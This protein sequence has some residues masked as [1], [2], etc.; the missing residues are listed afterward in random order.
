MPDFPVPPRSNED[1]ERAAIDLRRL[2][3]LDQAA[4]FIGIRKIVERASNLRG[5]SLNGLR[6]IELSDPDMNQVDASA[7]GFAQFDPPRITIRKSVMERAE[8]GDG[9]ARM[10]VVHE[11][12]HIWLN[13]RGEAKFRTRRFDTSSFKPPA[14]K[15]AEHQASYGAAAFMM[16]LD[17]LRP[18]DTITELCSRYG[19][20][21]RAAEIRIEQR[22]R[23]GARVAPEEVQEF[24]Q[25]PRQG[26][27]N[28]LRKRSTVEQ[29]AWEKAAQV[30]NEDPSIFRLCLKGNRVKRDHHLKTRSAMG[31]CVQEGLVRSYTDLS[32]LGLREDVDASL[33][34]SPCM[35]CGSIA[36][37]RTASFCKCDVCGK[38][39][40]T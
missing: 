12:F 14:H 3:K 22:R 35:H 6:L 4:D 15:S 38:H 28:G 30:P 13:H 29:A 27:T 17:A 19:V 1:L 40:R 10:T 7:D 31:W 39:W 5:T 23:Y 25:H 37:R 21:K 24:L 8:G 36:V 26:I 32:R 9:R 2:L 16:P 18:M 20:S 34:D 33:T 11:L